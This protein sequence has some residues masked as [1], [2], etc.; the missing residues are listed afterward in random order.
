[1][2]GD[3]VNVGGVRSMLTA[4]DVNV[5]LLPASSVTVTV[6]VRPLPSA[7]KCSGLG[8]DADA[9]PDRLSCVV[10]AMST[11]VLF[12]FAPFGAGESAPND[13]VG[14]VASIQI[15]CVGCGVSMSPALSSLQNAI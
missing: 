6:C 10:N 13:S 12:Q 7:P 15:V 11:G 14:G 5:A 2:L 3:T 4:G 9:T 8:G 1:M